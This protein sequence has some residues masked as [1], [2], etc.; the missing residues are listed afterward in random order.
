LAFISATGVKRNQGVVIATLRRL[1]TRRFLAVAI[2]DIPNMPSRPV[3]ASE[4]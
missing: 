3:G 4:R 1:D 2:D